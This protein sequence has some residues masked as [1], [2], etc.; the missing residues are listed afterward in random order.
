M[1]HMNHDIDIAFFAGV[2]QLYYM[3]Y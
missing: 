1:T 2:I 3:N